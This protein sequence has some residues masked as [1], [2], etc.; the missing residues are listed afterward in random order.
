MNRKDSAV[1]ATMYRMKSNTLK[2]NVNDFI[3]EPTSNAPTVIVTSSNILPYR[4]APPKAKGIGRCQTITG[5]SPK[6]RVHFADLNE[7]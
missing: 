3:D 6:G 1:S 4:K 2:L 5:I 7:E